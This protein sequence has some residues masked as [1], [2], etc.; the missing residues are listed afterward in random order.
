M[1]SKNSTTTA[2]RGAGAVGKKAPRSVRLHEE[3]RYNVYERVVKSVSDEE[4][5]A[6]RISDG[7][8]DGPVYIVTCLE[9]GR[10]HYYKA[11]VPDGLSIIANERVGED[12]FEKLVGFMRKGRYRKAINVES[13]KVKAVAYEIEERRTYKPTGAT[14]VE[15]Y[16]VVEWEDSGY[17]YKVTLGRNEYLDWIL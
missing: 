10:G 9:K 17:V 7:E 13:V 15:K 8:H 16:T 11:L 14:F 2:P 1:V 6:L 5:T 4:F 12:A 3:D